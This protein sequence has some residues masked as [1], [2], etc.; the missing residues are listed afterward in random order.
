MGSRENILNRLRA[1]SLPYAEQPAAAITPLKTAPLPEDSPA[2]LRDL[3]IREATAL[4]AFVYQ[5]GDGKEAIETILQIIRDDKRL[6]AWD[7]EQMPAF[8]LQEALANSGIEI[9][10]PRDGEVRVGI[11]GVDGALA[12]TGSLALLAAPGQSRGASL[13]PPVHI[14]LLKADQIY[15]DLEGWL[16]AQTKNP[17]F[18]KS[19]GAIIISG[20][21][22]TADIG[23]ELILGMHG[24]KELH[25]MVYP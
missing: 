22:R 13:L 8:G 18:R 15:P 9:A 19:S 4:Q 2:A 5:P 20:A 6:M 24:P 11:T 16:A 25:I 23:A 17:A 14:A 21:S 7:W 12:A 3:F 1:A 10:P